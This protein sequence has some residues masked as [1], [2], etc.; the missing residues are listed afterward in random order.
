MRTDTRDE[1]SLAYLIRLT[2]TALPGLDGRIGVPGPD[3]LVCGTPGNARRLAA[4]HE[5][6]RQ[7]HPE[8]G[9]HYWAVRTWT[10]L[11][12]QPIYLSLLAVHVAGLAPILT[13]LGQSVENAFVGGYSL[14]EHP[15]H[16][17][18]EST[19]IQLAGKEIRTVI[20]AQIAELNSAGERFIAPK[21]ARL[22]AVDCVCAALLL[23]QQEQALDNESLRLLEQHWLKSLAQPPV[24]A[25]LTLQLD[26]GREC[27]GLDRRA[28]CLHFHRSDGEP[29][30]SCPKLEQSERLKRMC[31][32]RVE[33]C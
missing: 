25:L 17:G 22:L 2:S 19:L 15:P 16:Q 24:S 23:V 29:C 26:D 4:L 6:L 12:W 13:H 8:A 9:K 14:P 7:H 31:K 5:E 1:S 28:C 30:N 32:E 11:I 20:E 21:L 33:T 18:D 3:Q 27:L 10:L